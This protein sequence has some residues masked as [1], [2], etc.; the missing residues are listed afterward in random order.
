MLKEFVVSKLKLPILKGIHIDL[1]SD[2]DENLNNFLSDCIPSQLQLLSINWGSKNF[3]S[4]KSGFY[5]SS[6]WKVVSI[7]T[8]EAYLSSFDFNE[9]ELQAIVQAAHNT[10]R[11]VLAF[12]SIHCSLALDFRT[13]SKY[14]IKSLSFQGWGRQDLKMVTTDWKSDPSCFENIV[15]AICNSGLKDSLQ[16][17]SIWANLTLSQENVQE[18]FNSK[19]MSHITIN[20]DYADPL[21]A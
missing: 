3:V 2:A 12:S 10:E 8:E 5:L 14:N 1:I 20:T 9:Q 18:L 11:L 4:I 21:L 7:V 13:D 19:G 15:N 16:N 6:L 17:I